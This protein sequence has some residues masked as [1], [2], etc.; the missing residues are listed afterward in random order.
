MKHLC[1]FVLFFI[2]IT[3][4]EKIKLSRETPK[5]LNNLHGKRVIA[6]EQCTTN[7]E[8]ECSDDR[9]IRYCTQS[10]NCDPQWCTNTLEGIPC[11]PNSY[12]CDGEP[13]NNGGQGCYNSCM[14]GT[15]S[16]C[17]HLD[18]QVTLYDGTV[19]RAG[20]V[21]MGEYLLGYDNTSNLVTFVGLSNV[22]WQ[23]M[24][25]INGGPFHF[26]V[27]HP[28]F[29][30]D[31]CVTYNKTFTT[32]QM[33]SDLV[34]GGKL[35]TYNNQTGWGEV[36]L[37]T[38][39]TRWMDIQTVFFFTST[40]TTVG[41]WESSGYV[42]HAGVYLPV[43]PIIFD[44]IFPRLQHMFPEPGPHEVLM[45]KRALQMTETRLPLGKASGSIW[46]TIA[47][48]YSITTG[49]PLHKQAWD[50]HV[51]QMVQDKAASDQRGAFHDHRLIATIILWS[52]DVKDLLTRPPTQENLDILREFAD[53]V[54]DWLE[55]HL[56]GEYRKKMSL[57]EFRD[58]MYTFDTQYH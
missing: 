34:V 8:E 13:C 2:C 5:S 21:K 15:C 42:T 18:A 3:A 14:D 19:K 25:S 49:P 43:S 22:K 41:T 45:Y 50:D 1:L 11:A 54:M 7:N 56:E 26:T 17:V 40:P 53:R 9:I 55:E 39:E 46:S 27:D 44:H 57:H 48:K 10:S 31:S 4:Y 38:I 24:M 58:V 36:D 51:S 35:S 47:S 52:S 6:N 30:K 23:L 28:M 29:Y 20:E 16:Q 37:R 12:L 33:C 32:S